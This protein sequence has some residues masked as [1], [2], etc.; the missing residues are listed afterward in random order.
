MGSNFLHH[1]CVNLVLGIDIF[2]RCTVYLDIIKV[3][4]SPTNALFIILE[5]SKIYIK[6]YIKMA[7]TCFAP[8]PSSEGLHLKL[9]EVKLTLKQSVKLRRYV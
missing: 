6:T 7:P 9:A 2:Y 4:H 5:N 3:F 8:R 1:K